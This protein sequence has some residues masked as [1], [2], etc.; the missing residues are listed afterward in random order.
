MDSIGSLGACLPSEFSLF[1]EG[2]CDVTRQVVLLPGGQLL[3]P[4]PGLEEEA[5]EVAEEEAGV[6]T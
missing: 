4:P 1:R 3:S 2:N 5:E 6:Q